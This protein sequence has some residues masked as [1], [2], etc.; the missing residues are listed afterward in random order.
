MIYEN[1]RRGW[2]KIEQQRKT[3]MKQEW[4]NRIKNSRERNKLELN[5][6]PKDTIVV[7]IITK[8]NK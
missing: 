2:E 5:E 4:W 6:T 3:E 8:G 7:V 1:K